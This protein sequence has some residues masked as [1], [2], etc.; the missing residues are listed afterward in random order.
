MNQQRQSSERTA[1]PLTADELQTRFNLRRVRSLLNFNALPSKLA[2]VR[3]TLKLKSNNNNG[4]KT[5]VGS[6]ISPSEISLNDSKT[7]LKLKLMLNEP[8]V[9]NCLWQYWCLLADCDMLALDNSGNL[10]CMHQQ[11]CLLHRLLIQCLMGERIVYSEAIAMAQVDWERIVAQYGRQFCTPR[12]HS[13]QAAL[14][15]FGFIPV[16]NATSNERDIE[17]DARSACFNEVGFRCS[18][19]S[20]ILEWTDGTKVKEAPELAFCLRTLLYAISFI[21]NKNI[22]RQSNNP[23]MRQILDENIIKERNAIFWSESVASSTNFQ[24]DL[25]DQRAFGQSLLPHLLNASSPILSNPRPTSP[26]CN[27]KCAI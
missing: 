10:C 15:Y 9:F 26:E 21:D 14:R 27:S 7:N 18:L 17:L 5:P 19:L 4:S 16:T 3:S 12:H 8:D 11:W 24:E 23:T 6:L 25:K 2:L 20:L 13:S 22:C 1:R